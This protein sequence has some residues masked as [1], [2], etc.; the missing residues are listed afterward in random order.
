[1]TA[2][3]TISATRIIQATPQAIWAALTTP[4]QVAVWWGPAGFTSTIQKMDVRPGGTWDFILHGP[5][6]TDYPN[7]LTYDVVEPDQRLSYIHHEVT[8]WGLAAWSAE[9]VIEDLGGSSRVTL[10]NRFATDEEKAKHVNNMGAVEG[11]NQTLER[12][13]ALIESK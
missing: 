1:M 13:A 5:D 11:A 9:V 4:D 7:S 6:G 10:T 2:D 12:L 3:S 8:E